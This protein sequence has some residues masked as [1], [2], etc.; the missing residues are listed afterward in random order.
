VDPTLP[1]HDETIVPQRPGFRGDR[2][3]DGAP[4]A[5]PPRRTLPL[6]ILAAAVLLVGVL[7]AFVW[8]PSRVDE[9][10][11]AAAAPA[12]T[13]APVVEPARPTLSA[14][15]QAALKK[16]AEELL[17][18]LLTLQ[19]RLTG[20]NVE[21]WANEDWQRYQ[22]LSTAGDDSFLANDFAAA[23]R[24]YSDADTLGN[25]LV[26]RAA[27]AVERSFTTAEAALAAGNAELAIQQYDL[28]LTIE[29]THSQALAQRERAVRLPDVLTLVQR[30]EGERTRG[31]LDAAVATY[32]EA[33]ALDAQWAPAGA[34]I[35]AIHRELRDAE[36]ERLLSEAFGLLG[37]E[38]FTDAQAR[39]KAALG[40]RPS[41]HE[42]QDGLEQAEQ[43]AKLEQIA[44]AEARG[45]AFERRELWDQAI[46]LYRSVLESDET[47]LFAQLGLERA[48]ARAGLDAKLTN[49]I[50]NPTLLLTDTVL[51]DARKLLEAAEGESTHGPRIDGQIE[52]LGRLITLASQPIAVRLT[53]D[54]LTT[55]TLYRVGQLGAFASRDLE[56]R[57]GTYT[58]IGSRDGYRD[59]RQTFTVRPGG[60]LGPINVVCVEPI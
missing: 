36:F 27:M 3:N 26:A 28:V 38:N 54:E 25:A 56:L 58:A 50:D 55:V 13:S 12:A 19:D 45:L 8:L 18:G 32:R 43:G 35:D 60:N 44:L 5:S 14:E 46:A 23:V 21:T 1:Q 40:V 10:R 24:S 59:V 30:A 15:Q 4:S 34:A 57:P 49:L 7:A 48:E 51:A 41:S 16:Q 31:E 6:T 22:E 47:L 17:A 2:P 53:S 33:L 37:D 20:L 29:P 39:F 42:A 11:A 52:Q 9:E